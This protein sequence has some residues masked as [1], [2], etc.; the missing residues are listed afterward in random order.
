MKSNSK[1]VINVAS[2]NDGSVDSTN[3]EDNNNNNNN[4]EDNN[5]DVE[6]IE[7]LIC[8]KRHVLQ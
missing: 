6:I 1:L 8:I 7:Q 3:D 2:N 5:D 4:N